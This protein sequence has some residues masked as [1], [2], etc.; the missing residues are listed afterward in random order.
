VTKVLVVEDEPDIALGIERD[1]RLDGYDVEVLNDGQRAIDRATLQAFDLI[2]LDV[3]C[4]AKT[5]LRFAENCG[6]QGR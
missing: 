5:A 1:L 4:L 6:V 3:G 2:L